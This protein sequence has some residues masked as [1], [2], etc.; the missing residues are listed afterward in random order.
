MQNIPKPLRNNSLFKFTESSLATLTGPAM[1][2]GCGGR[3]L[4]I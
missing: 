4:K 3:L 2:E 1:R